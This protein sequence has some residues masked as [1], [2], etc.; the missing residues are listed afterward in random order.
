M[1][2]PLHLVLFVSYLGTA[3]AARQGRHIGIDIAPRFLP[4]RALRVVRVGIEFLAMTMAATLA[5]AAWRY[6]VTV[7]MGGGAAVATIDITFGSTKAF[8]IPSWI[9]FAVAP[10]GFVFTTYHFLVRALRRLAGEDPDAEY[11]AAD[12]GDEIPADEE[13]AA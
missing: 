2:M 3:L 7:E 9:F 13:V 11:L 1:D 10:V 12:E 6:L 5:F 4:P 8:G